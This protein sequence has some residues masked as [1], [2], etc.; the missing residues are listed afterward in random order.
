VVRVFT[1]EK[2]ARYDGKD[3]APAY[4]AYK[5][6]VYDVSHSLLWRGGRHWVVVQAGAD[7]TDRLPSAPHG[8]DLLSRVPA[9]GILE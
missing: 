9:I 5:G 2:L 1:A 4:I 3:G 8:E 6:T 7:L